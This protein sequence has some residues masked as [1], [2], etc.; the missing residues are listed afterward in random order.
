MTEITVTRHVGAP[1][2]RVWAVFTDLEHAPERL[3]GVKSVEMLS[4]G[5]FGVGTRWRETRVMYGKE[6]SEEMTIAESEP[7]HRY[8]ATAESHGARYRSVFEFSPAGERT[9]VR[10]TFS[11]EPTT[12]AMRIVGVVTMPLMRRS[13]SKALTKDLDDLAAACEREAA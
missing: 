6:A 9:E 2:D 4:E 11:G 13:V 1:V 10:M 5:S 8:V 7:P 12:T 3:S